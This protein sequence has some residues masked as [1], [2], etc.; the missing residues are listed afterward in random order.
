MALEESSMG[1]LGPQ[2]DKQVDPKSIKPEIFWRQSD[3]TEAVLLQTH[4]EKAGFLR[5]ENNAGKCRR[6]WK[7]RNTKYDRD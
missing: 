1:T 2:E 6:Q 3:K 7:K 5:K 4:W